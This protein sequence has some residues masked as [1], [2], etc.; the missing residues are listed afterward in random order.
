MAIDNITGSIIATGA[1]VLV[2]VGQTSDSCT[3]VIG[4]A[5][6]VSYSENFQTQDAVVIG[7]LGP[8]SIDPNGYTCEIT[9]GCFIPAKLTM[10]ASG[11]YD[12]TASKAVN[13]FLPSRSGIETDGI[14]KAF[15]SLEFYNQKTGVVIAKFS[16]VIITNAGMNI[17]GNAYVK[18]NVQMRAL[19]RVVFS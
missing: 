10:G 2:R 3:E 19:E 6:N 17:D 7:H 13:E 12:A 1:N 9:I 5:T 16:G 15:R 8:V 18:S 14:K 11:T 4:L